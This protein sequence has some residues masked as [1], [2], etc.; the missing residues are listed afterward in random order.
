MRGVQQQRR[1]LA[2]HLGTARGGDARERRL[3]QL[4]VQRGGAA[5]QQRLRG[6]DGEQGVAGLVLAEEGEE[7]LLVAAGD[8]L[9]REHLPAD[10]RGAGE[11]A[12]L[13]PLDGGLRAELRHALAQHVGGVLVGLLGEDRDRLGG[14]D[15]GLLP[16]DLGDRVAEVLLVVQGDRGDHGDVG[17]DRAGRV[18]G[19]AEAG[20]DHGD[21]HGGGGE[22]LEGHRGEVLEVGQRRAAGGLRLGV[23]DL[24]EGLDVAIG[25]EEALLVDGR[26]VDRDPLGGRVEVGARGAARTQPGLAQYPLEDPRGGG[27]A[28]GAGDADRA[29]GVLGVA[30]Q[31]HHPADPA[32]VRLDAVLRG[33]LEERGIDLPQLGGHRRTGGTRAGRTGHC[34]SWV[35]GGTGRISVRGAPGT[36]GPDDPGRGQPGTGRPGHRR[37]GHRRPGHG[38]SGHGRPLLP[39][40]R[41]STA[42][43]S[44]ARARPRPP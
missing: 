20:L 35:R 6:G 27:L 17:V 25:L 5:A 21:V 12:D 23:D 36:R 19:A 44:P 38:R 16:R 3:Q 32:E 29:V 14:E 42:R 28:V 1:R 7:H 34:G 4:A 37:P 18:P 10:A 24:R 26:A 11:H 43:L 2:H 41:S 30:H 33:A 8:P 31:L 15:P 40:S 13:L 39:T 9:Q 22:G